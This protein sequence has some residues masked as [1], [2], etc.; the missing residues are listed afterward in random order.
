MQ[1]YDVSKRPWVLM[2]K[3]LQAGSVV[4]DWRKFNTVELHRVI[5]ID[6]AI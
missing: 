5:V 2:L 3:K 6:V 4:G 1:V